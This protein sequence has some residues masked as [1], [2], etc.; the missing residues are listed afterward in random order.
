MMI[1]E[2]CQAE[3]ETL[4]RREPI[5]P[6]YVASPGPRVL[7]TSTAPYFADLTQRKPVKK[8]V[9]YICPSCKRRQIV[10]RLGE[11]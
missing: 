2:E 8:Y 11:T 6:N 7:T 1:C 10:A 4:E 5:D 9:T 3:M